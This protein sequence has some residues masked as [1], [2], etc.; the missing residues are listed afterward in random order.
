MLAWK[1]LA[2]RYRTEVFFARTWKALARSLWAESRS[3]RELHDLFLIEQDRSVKLRRAL[4]GAEMKV[5]A[6]RRLCDHLKDE[7]RKLREMLRA[8]GY[9]LSQ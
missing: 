6:H 9:W 1:K 3:Y 7:N 8:R 2:K 5:D 4:D